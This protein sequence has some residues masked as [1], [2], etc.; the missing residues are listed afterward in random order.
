MEEKK[1]SL[2]EVIENDPYR[3]HIISAYVAPDGTVY[4]DYDCSL[5][6]LLPPVPFPYEFEHIHHFRLNRGYKRH[7]RRFKK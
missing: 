7:V 6:S 5:I 3:D 2:R 4:V 1:K